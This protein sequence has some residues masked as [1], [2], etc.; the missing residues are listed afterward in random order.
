MKIYTKTGD[1]GQTSLIGGSR[2]SKDDLRVEC[3]GT[4]DE[5]SAA[6]GVA[7]A[8]ITNNNDMREQIRAIQ[9]KLLTLGAQLAADEKGLELLKN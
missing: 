4:I 5:L 7:F 8:A 2:I 3:Y 1:K 9:T 6:L